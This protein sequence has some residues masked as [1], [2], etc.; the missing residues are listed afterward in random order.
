MCDITSI[1]RI[2]LHQI[3]WSLATATIY[4]CQKLYFVAVN[5][6]TF[7]LKLCAKSERNIFLSCSGS[8]GAAD[9]FAPVLMEK[10]IKDI[11]KIMKLSAFQSYENVMHP[12]CENPDAAPVLIGIMTILQ[13]VNKRMATP[14]SSWK[15]TG[16]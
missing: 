2:V 14:K 7:G 11:T 9:D 13:G 5:I 10:V 3:K 6:S 16:N 8:S 4:M 15:K 1:S 12:A